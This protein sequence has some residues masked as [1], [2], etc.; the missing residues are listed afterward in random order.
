MI[1]IGGCFEGPPAGGRLAARYTA[2]EVKKY[3]KDLDR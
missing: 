1:N 3:G 2:N